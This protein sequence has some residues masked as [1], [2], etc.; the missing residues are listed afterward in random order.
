[1]NA[2]IDD[3]M[4]SLFSGMGDDFGFWWIFWFAI[5]CMFAAA[6]SVLAA[7]QRRRGAWAA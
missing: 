2:A 7:L 5:A 3:E 6:N 1:M 4:A